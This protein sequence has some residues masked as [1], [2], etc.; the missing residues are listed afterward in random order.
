MADHC[1]LCTILQQGINPTRVGMRIMADHC[2]LCT[3][4][5]HGINLTRVGMR[6]MADHCVLCTILQ[7]GINPTRVGMRIMA[8]HCVRER[9]FS[10]LSQSA[11]SFKDSSLLQDIPLNHKER[12]A[13]II[14][15]FP[16]YICVF[17]H[18]CVACLL[19]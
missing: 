18:A 13:I 6:I 12:K 15:H 11:L 8:D 19:A 10:L 4:L 2:V 16:T 1:V 3:I 7:H 5:Q 14:T 9:A 17:A